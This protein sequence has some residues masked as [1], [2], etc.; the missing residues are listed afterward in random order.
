[1]T[2][3]K[4]N[5]NKN[6]L[7]SFQN[8]PAILI[9]GARQVGKRTLVEKMTKQD[10]SAKYF[11]FDDHN[12]LFAA[13][14]DPYGFLSQ[15]T[16][17]LALDEVQRHPEIFISI[18]RI[19]DETKKNGKFLLT[20]SANI[21][22]M[23]KISESLAGR[24]IIHNLW[25]LSQGEINNKTEKFIDWAFTEH[26]IPQLSNILKINK[27]IDII[28]TGGYPR[29]LT[30]RSAID[31]NEW[32]NSY[33]NTILQRDIKNLA[34]IEGLK[35]LPNILS[36]LANR[37]GNLLNL[38]DISRMA[39]INQVTLKRYYTLLQMVFLVCEVPAWF[40]NNDKVL[41]KTP[42]IFLNDTGLLSHFKKLSKDRLLENRTELGPLVEN[43]VAMELKKQI[44]WHDLKPDL[45]H[46]R[47]RSG[48][49]IDFL[50]EGENKN[51]V[52]IEV[53]TT[54]TLNKKDL[55][56]LKQLREKLGNTFIKGILLYNGTEP[57]MLE[58]RIYAL[59]LN[60]L[61]DIN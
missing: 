13:S 36:I 32:F 7:R 17:A 33:I 53:K 59:P 24:I 3:Y 25:P 18:K 9:N 34:N 27:L 55:I 56:S 22:T 42:K 4:R 6:L 21:L 1:M 11:T 31:R 52:A 60:A 58:D 10:L 45:Y 14:S 54:A 49:E 26:K 40:S 44:S 19:I 41:S 35:E 5:I 37:V 51:I 8:N 20:G 15:Y 47:T 29:S 46:Y 61:W 2:I 57:L 30:S 39:K 48:S 38:Q 28:L 16:E 12:I 23:P 43:F 50:L